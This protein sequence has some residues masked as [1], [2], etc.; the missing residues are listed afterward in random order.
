MDAVHAT[1]RHIRNWFM[2]WFV[3]EAAVATAAAGRC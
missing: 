1:L 2:V 3:A